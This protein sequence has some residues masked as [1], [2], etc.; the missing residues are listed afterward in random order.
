MLLLFQNPLPLFPDKRAKLTNCMAHFLLSC[1][2]RGGRPEL[3]YRAP[4]ERPGRGG[5]T[6]QPHFTGV[7]S[8]CQGH[9]GIKKQRRAASAML[10]KR[11]PE[12]FSWRG[13]CGPEQSSPLLS[14]GDA[15]VGAITAPSRC[16][17]VSTDR[18]RRLVTSHGLTGQIC[19]GL[20]LTSSEG[21]VTASLGP[22]PPSV[23]GTGIVHSFILAACD[24]WPRRKA[25]CSPREEL[26][27]PGISSPATRLA[28]S[29]PPAQ[30][31]RRLPL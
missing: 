10:R 6:K 17:R 19:C 23:P 12:Y 3:S 21:T 18:W 16:C 22:L 26:G 30:P 8:E 11:T 28:R 13:P 9:R 29:E 2:G 24:E 27:P 20:G 15:N 7:F 5:R 1:P 14:G 31:A 4:A 25:R